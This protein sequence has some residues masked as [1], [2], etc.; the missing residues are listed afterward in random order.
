M[1]VGDNVSSHDEW[2]GYCSDSSCESEDDL[3]DDMVMMMTA[4]GW[5]LPEAVREA[6]ALGSRP[7]SRRRNDDLAFS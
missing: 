4:A 5:L 2:T 6:A 3:V 7:W 1:P